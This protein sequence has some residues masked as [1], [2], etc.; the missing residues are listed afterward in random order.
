M[1]LNF[2]KKPKQNLIPCGV[3]YTVEP[4]EKLSFE[5]WVK[6]IRFSKQYS[7]FN[8][9]FIEDDEIVETQTDF[10]I[11]AILKAQKNISN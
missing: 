5:Q 9:I 10:K 11:E 1:L 7:T 4:T 8:N 6:D 2:F 3:G